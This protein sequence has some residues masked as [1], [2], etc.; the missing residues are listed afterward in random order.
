M[1]NKSG[2]KGAALDMLHMQQGEKV[3]GEGGGGNKESEWG[4]EGMR[5][6]SS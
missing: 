5:G 2:H 4:R 3:Q 1:L 6:R